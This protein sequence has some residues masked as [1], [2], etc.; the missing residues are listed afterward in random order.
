[1][2]D[3]VVIGI[4]GV[5]SFALRA[6]VKESKNNVL[7]IERYALNHAKGSSHGQS[8]IYRRAYFENTNYV[9][10]IEY[11]LDQ[12][13]K[14]EASSGL[15]LKQECGMLLAQEDHG[16]YLKTSLQSASEYNVPV[17]TL[18]VGEMRERFPQFRFMSQEM[19]GVFEP[20]AGVLRP[21]RIIK[22][23]TDEAKSMGAE[24]WE[25]KQ[26]QSMKEIKDGGSTYV[27]LIVKHSNGE[28]ELIQTRSAL[29]AA[30]AWTSELIPSYAPHLT[31]TRQ[32]Q[33]WMNIANL[34]NLSS[35]RIGEMPAFVIVTPGWPKP[36]YGLPADEGCDGDAYKSCV[37]V[38]VHERP[39]IVNPNDN[40]STVL[41]EELDEMK[42]AMQTGLN[43]EL[44]D[45]PIQQAE[46]CL[47]TMTEDTNYMIGVPQE[48]TNVCA[49]AGLSGHGFKMI[50]ALGQMLADFALERDLAHWKT[51]FCSP[52]RFGV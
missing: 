36:L 34:D 20:G 40:P 27:E 25:N 44:C 14:L 21:E 22:A 49:V 15:S 52:R 45:L 50:P 43:Q 42:Q 32:L 31:V 9:P 4:G 29:V 26:I 35:Y 8:R 16:G 17:E 7:G 30:G 39:I 33:C 5:G 12:F 24:I 41:G 23:A 38:G 10:W 6:L 3:A 19:M 37:K 11:S 47:Y 48:F 1:M 2:L 13:E 51:D 46:P 18:T 28:T